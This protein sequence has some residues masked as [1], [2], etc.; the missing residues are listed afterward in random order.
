VFEWNHLYSRG[1]AHN[2][3]SGDPKP[4]L[5]DIDVKHEIKVAAE[6]LGMGDA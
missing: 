3:P 5:D 1:L 6:A 2:H 4:S